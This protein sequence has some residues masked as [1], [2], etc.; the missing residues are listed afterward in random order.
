MC[1][2]IQ[3]GQARSSSLP[4]LNIV[5]TQHISDL[6]STYRNQT[7]VN[8]TVYVTSFWSRLVGRSMWNMIYNSSVLSIWKLLSELC[9][10]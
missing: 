8:S 3:I 10:S 9:Y 6:N 1:H 5:I 7:N 4:N 2:Y